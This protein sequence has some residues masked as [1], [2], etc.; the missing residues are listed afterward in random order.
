MR[1]QTNE[2][3]PVRKKKKKR[4]VLVVLLLLLI[5]IVTCG[6][7]FL[8]TL[9]Q[10]PKKAVEQFLTAAQTLDFD[11]MSQVIKN[12]DL[13]PLES[14]DL[15]SEAY[16]DFFRK[17]NSKMTFE[18][19]NLDYQWD[20]ATVTADIRYL[21]GT[22]LYKE[23]ISDFLKQVVSSSFAGKKLNTSDYEAML[24]GLLTE[25]ADTIT[26]EYTQ[27]SV[28][29]PLEKTGDTWVISEISEDTLQVISAN[30]KSVTGDLNS[31][32]EDIE[33]GTDDTSQ[34]GSQSAETSESALSLKTDLMV[35]TY[36]THKVTKD[37]NGN[38]CLLVYY[39]Y[40]NNSGE[41]ASPMVG[42][43]LRAYQK[44]TACEVAIPA[45]DDSALENYMKEVAPGATM[46][47]C[48]A[49]ALSDT[50]D[51]TLELS[52]SYSFDNNIIRQTIK[53][54]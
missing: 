48:Q 1:K 13:S 16:Q 34:E 37:I 12:G 53:L 41:S 23:S 26:D 28:S 44:D 33:N 38:P 31:S 4:T 30:F 46:R 3:L 6:G 54:Q 36:Q 5:V 49:F 40:T 25:K 35:V 39:D 45:E 29:Y 51:V 50:S 32:I 11:S 42:V 22:Q 47:V 8:Y 14:A 15:T 18:I 43:I 20:H 2:E 17:V 52:E 7:I 24:S 19:T 10:K 9:I 21:D 27:M